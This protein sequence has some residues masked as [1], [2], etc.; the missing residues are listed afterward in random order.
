MLEPFA[1]NGPPQLLPKRQ[2][3]PG[4]LAYA[5]TS[6]YADTLPASRQC[7]ILNRGGIGYAS[8][9]K[10][11]AI[12]TR[13][14]DASDEERQQ[15]RQRDRVPVLEAFH[16]GLLK[17][18]VNPESRLGEAI[19]YTLTYWNHLTVYCTDGRVEIDNDRIEIKIRPFAVSR[20]NGLFSASRVGGA[21]KPAPIAIAW[22][23]RPKPNPKERVARTIIAQ[24]ITRIPRC[25]AVT[26]PVRCLTACLSR[27]I[28]L[29]QQLL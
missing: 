17:Q 15:A 5:I 25:G 29:A 11:S 8:N 10:L 22:L 14:R 1:R 6:K 7:Y 2:V 19:H 16:T 13:M 24:N 26:I 12:E 21:P 23:K 4:F 9:T 27:I 18:N 28:Y 20:T 3:S